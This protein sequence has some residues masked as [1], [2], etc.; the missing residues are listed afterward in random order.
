[1]S[2]ETLIP[3]L[4]RTE[5][6]KIVS[7]LC[8]RFG[9]QHVQTAEDIVSDTFLLASESWA[10]KGLPD[11]PK[12]WL[13]KVAI[14]RT[15]DYLKRD[16][17][18][19]HT[20][21]DTLKEK[22]EVRLEDFSLD[23]SDEHIEDSLLKM[24]F[25]ICDTSISHDSQVMLALRVLC[26]FSIE[27]I[28]QAFLTTKSVI[29]KRL[30]RAK[31]NLKTSQFSLITPSNHDIVTRLPQVLSVLY[32][33]FNEGYYTTSTSSLIKKSLCFEA[34]SLT[35][36]LV[37]NPLTNTP[38]TYALFSLICFHL[39]RFDART[40]YQNQPILYDSQDKS[41][42]DTSLIERG[43]HYLFLSAKGNKASKYHLEAGIAF[44]HTRKEDLKQKW[45]E[46]LQLYNQLLQIEYS[47][48]IALNRTY[49]LSKVKGKAIA[50]TEAK[51]LELTQLSAY[52]QLL[53][54]LSTDP[55]KQKVY[56]KKAF[57]L[58]K[59]EAEK[60]II[61]EKIQTLSI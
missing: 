40:D 43:E 19:Q 13:Y 5:F 47:P 21:S 16:T 8:S 6:S 54:A 38:E 4:F 35:Y 11:H 10:L 46:I 41:K 55:L 60:C 23:L 53:A 57:T 27:E 20:I 34:M 33:L 58:T 50:Y 51:K 30:F 52:Y 25:V 29:N 32:L 39:S 44:W 61:E 26:G 12:A 14:N 45:H 59:S 36:L 56:L 17:L 42:W 15:K 24:L 31:K 28:A 49:A 37:K 18:F 1:M 48:I 2:T 7:V 9:Y 22:E 3:H